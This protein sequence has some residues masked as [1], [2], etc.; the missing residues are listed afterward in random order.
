MEKTN[1][2]KSVV[3]SA[4][5]D[6]EFNKSPETK[7]DQRKGSIKKVSVIFLLIL[8]FLGC[9]YLIFRPSGKAKGLDFKGLNNS[10]PQV[11]ELQME[12][13]KQK[14]Y[15]SQLLAEK[16]NHDNETLMGL[17][18]YFEKEEAQVDVK[19]PKDEKMLSR[20]FSSDL[21]S[22][23]DAQS[24]INGFYN[25]KTSS[26]EQ[27]LEKEILSLKSE[28]SQRNSSLGPKPQDPLALIEKSY[29]LAAKYFPQS[30]TEQ[31]LYKE[32]R[33]ERDDSDKD[34]L[35]ARREKLEK[36]VS[37]LKN[38]TLDS[39]SV[40]L[41][42]TFYTSGV[43]EESQ[44]L[45]NSFKAMVYKT[46][47]IYGQGD[48]SLRLLEGMRIQDHMMPA[49]TLL[50]AK[51][52]LQQGRLEMKISSVLFKGNIIPT[53]IDVYDSTGQLGL[54]VG[55]SEEMN[56]G[57]E[58]LANMGQGTGMNITMTNSASQQVLSDLARGAMQGISGYFSKKI[59]V[60][61]A[62]LKAGIM[63]YLRSKK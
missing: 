33:L 60:P 50:L 44:E 26:R 61:K 53:D 32:E 1:E 41:T 7:R 49:G 10:V 57:R 28:L 63:V 38:K 2:N 5:K 31:K 25:S 11:G 35:G 62:T 23:R 34:I 42:N 51:G 59:K 55:G 22:Y 48:I 54:R 56:A 13:D 19:T 4:H 12:S 37:L 18:N 20:D 8:L 21:N 24:T 6:K 16:E 15:E 47:V 40:F 3:L 58:I 14:V 9:I 43:T 27:L 45:G 46:Q 30:T 39:T 36:V 52:K 17:S 29:E